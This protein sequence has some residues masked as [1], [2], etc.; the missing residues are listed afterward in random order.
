[1]QNGQTTLTR[2]RWNLWRI[3]GWGGAAALVLLPAVT[4]QFTSEVNWT[5]SDFGFAAMLFGVLGLGIELAVRMTPDRFYRAGAAFALLSAFL[6]VW[7][8]GAVGMIGNEDNPVNLLFLGV[9][10]IAL[11]GSVLSRFG[12]QGMA[13]TM[14]TAGTAQA[15]IAT[16]FGILG[17]DFRGGV[18]SI[19]LASLW[20]L[21]G[22]LF[23]AS[24]C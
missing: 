22:A 4:M 15:S 6:I 9:I 3:I 7:S 20:I 14:F 2:S 24:R 21:S 5:L 16:I 17:S 1:M 12:K 11:I 10:L 18:Y 13:L 8:N 23:R 19:V